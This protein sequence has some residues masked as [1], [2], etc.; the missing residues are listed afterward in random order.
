MYA[1]VSETLSPSDRKHFK[2]LISKGPKNF[3]SPIA[4]LINEVFA[5]I[6]SRAIKL[7]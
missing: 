3:F 7:M 1:T 2:A 5:V 6:L 4:N